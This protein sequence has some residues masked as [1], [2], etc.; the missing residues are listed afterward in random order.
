[1]LTVCWRI[2]SMTHKN[3]VQTGCWHWRQAHRRWGG[4]FAL[5]LVL[6]FRQV[7]SEFHW[8]LLHEL[9]RSLCWHEK[10]GPARGFA[11]RMGETFWCE[12]KRLASLVAQDE[13]SRE[14]TGD[15]T[16]ARVNGWYGWGDER[17]GNIQAFEVDV[18]SIHVVWLS[19]TQDTVSEMFKVL[20]AP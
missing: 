14:N 11:T 6:V 1:M 12:S 20:L 18:L 9:L 13:V 10:A 19:M 2:T 4:R 15:S 17:Q 3:P 16:C 7:V 5:G 8:S